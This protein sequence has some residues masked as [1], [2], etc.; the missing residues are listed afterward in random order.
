MISLVLYPSE[1]EYLN[2]PVRGRGGM[3]SLL[4]SLFLTRSGCIQHLTP[5]QV[6]R[7]KRYA[8]KYGGGGFQNRL[9]S[10]ALRISDNNSIP[11]ND[12]HK[13]QGLTA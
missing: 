8:F 1:V 11:R 7:I 12:E 5:T 4:R 2:L 3:Q 13:S 9:L 6:E 10:I